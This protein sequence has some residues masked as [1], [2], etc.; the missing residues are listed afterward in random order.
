MK[1]RKPKASTGIALVMVF[2]LMIAT[3]VLNW[4]S[5]AHATNANSDVTV[6]DPVTGDM[7]VFVMAGALSD[8]VE[9]TIP[10][11]LAIPSNEPAQMTTEDPATESLAPD[12]N[13]SGREEDVPQILDPADPDENS[14]G[15][16]YSDPFNAESGQPQE[17]VQPQPNEEVGPPI[18]LKANGDIVTVDKDGNEIIIDHLDYRL[19]FNEYGTVASVYSDGSAVILG[20]WF[21]D[22]SMALY[23]EP[24]NGKELGMA[25]AADVGPD[26]EKITYLGGYTFIEGM[27]ANGS[28]LMRLLQSLWRL[29][30]EESLFSQTMTYVVADGESFTVDVMD[31][32][33]TF[34]V[35]GGNLE[36][37]DFMS[38]I[39]ALESIQ[40]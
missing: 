7:P 25:I 10:P 34:T 29:D 1:L 5:A 18:M 21:G 11:V 36:A 37:M 2:A 6:S 33:A 27:N 38:V 22:G 8:D 30:I 26:G 15:N 14:P 3:M 19:V 32:V 31:T 28:L 17:E 16:E 12:T 13:G 20:V 9:E 4:P 24:A 39:Q 40:G 23:Q 35:P